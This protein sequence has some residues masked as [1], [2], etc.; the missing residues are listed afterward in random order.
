MD[1]MTSGNVPLKGLMKGL[2]VDESTGIM[3]V[4]PGPVHRRAMQEWYGAHLPVGA[5]LANNDQLN[6]FTALK[7]R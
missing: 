1:K 2:I 5:D 7:N 6:P 3:A 4:D